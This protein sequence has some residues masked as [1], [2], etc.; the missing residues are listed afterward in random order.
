MLSFTFLKVG[1][2]SI[3]C[4]RE[5]FLL[6]I[7]ILVVFESS[8]HR[9]RKWWLLLQ[10]IKGG[11]QESSSSRSVAGQ[12]LLCRSCSFHTYLMQPY[13]SSLP[14]TSPSLPA[15]LLSPLV[16]GHQIT[17]VSALKKKKSDFISV[18]VNV[19]VVQ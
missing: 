17:S 4:D 19:F 6:I 3:T 10:S 8:P 5:I 2:G 9:H 7:D 15:R 12:P 11:N 14:S 18:E 16:S 1:R 13:F